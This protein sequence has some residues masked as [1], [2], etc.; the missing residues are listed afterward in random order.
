MWKAVLEE[1]FEDFLRFFYSDADE[2]FDMVKG[3][4]YLDKELE[5]LFPPE[6]NQFAPRFV[7]KLVKVFKKDGS[8]DWLLIHIEVQGQYNKDFAERMFTYYYRIKDKYDKPITA[9]A[10]F[11]DKNKSFH[12]NKY[13]YE[14]MGTRVSYKF[15]TYKIIEQD[16]AELAL[17]PN[18]FSLVI[19]VVLTALKVKDMN[20]EVL[21]GLKRNL[22]NLMLE[23]KI[24][25]VSR[26]GIF[27]FMRYYVSFENKETMLIFDKEIEELTGRITTMGTEQYLLEKAKNTGIQEGIQKGAELTKEQ[28]VKNLITQLDL[29]DNQI[30]GIVEVSVDFI[31]KIRA[32]LK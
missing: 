21:L 9:F 12:P 13:E 22:L 11:T 17:N 23:K 1:V 24:S 26:N 27:N 30:A 4:E 32:E 20:D 19:L 14:Y 10:I 15:N 2:L 31:K 25:R 18:P 8:E 29:S 3:F 7:D 28:T 16:E 5:Q 6:D